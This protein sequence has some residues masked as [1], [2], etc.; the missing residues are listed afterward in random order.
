MLQGSVLGPTLYTLYTSD[1][2]Q[3]NSSYTATYADD[4]V[5]L[6]CHKNTNIA[7]QKL[8]L[9]LNAIDVWL[10]KCRIKPNVLKSVQITFTLKKY[11]CT[12][13][14]F[15]NANLSQRTVVNYLGL[16]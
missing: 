13:W 10:R 7:L 9:N 16:H 11:L 12:Q 15:V 6:S 4:T 8:Q 3:L 2:P 1:L 5:I 14:F